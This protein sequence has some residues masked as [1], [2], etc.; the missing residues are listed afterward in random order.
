MK[1]ENLLEKLH[2]MEV[3]EFLKYDS[4]KF[5]TLALYVPY[6]DVKELKKAYEKYIINGREKNEFNIEDGVLTLKID[7]RQNILGSICSAK[8]SYGYNF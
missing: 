5:I 7:V 8:A 4:P 1:K 6:Y 3:K 2:K